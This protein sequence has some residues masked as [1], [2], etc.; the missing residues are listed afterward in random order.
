M[1]LLYLGGILIS[2]IG[3][4][5]IDARWRLA[6]FARPLRAL[7]AVGGTAFVLLMFDLAAIA[8]G[9]FVIGASEWMTGLEIL[10]HLPIEELAFL[11]FFSYVSLVAVAGAARFLESR[12][13]EQQ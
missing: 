7:I 12:R 5:I 8:T 6:L 2:A 3:V 10:P 1:S 13:R 9:S 4:G 11:I